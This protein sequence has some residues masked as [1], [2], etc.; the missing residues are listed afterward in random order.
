MSTQIAP[1][2]VP[3]SASNLIAVSNRRRWGIVWLLFF[4]SLIN[5][6]DRQTLSFVLPL[7]AK[8]FHLDA[9]QKGLLSSAFFWT[10]AA[11][12]I[13]MGLFADRSNMRWLYAAAFA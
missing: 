13:P 6:F 8:D 11:L 10:Y 1:A 3:E 7:L 5:Y 2:A 4:G 12:Q 9:V